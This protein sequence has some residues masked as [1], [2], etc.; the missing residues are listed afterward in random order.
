MKVLQLNTGVNSAIVSSMHD[1]SRNY[2]ANHK[3]RTDNV[4]YGGLETTLVCLQIL[5]NTSCRE[6]PCV[7]VPGGIFGNVKEGVIPR[8]SLLYATVFWKTSIG[9]NANTGER[10]HE[11]DEEKYPRNEKHVVFNVQ[12]EKY[13][14]NEKH[15]AR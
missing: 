3:D 6:V 11:P 8:S 9:C 12:R 13:P 5:N 15:V 1:E 10:V 4:D 14:R 7:W 2:R